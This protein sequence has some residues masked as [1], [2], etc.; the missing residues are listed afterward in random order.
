MMYILTQA[1]FIGHQFIQ[2]HVPHDRILLKRYTLYR[3]LTFTS[4][5]GQRLI[6]KSPG[7]FWRVSV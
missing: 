7:Y 4:N 2:I 6:R 5:H 3:Q 1:F